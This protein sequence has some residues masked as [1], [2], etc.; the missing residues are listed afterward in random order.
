MLVKNYIDFT[1]S[2]IIKEQEDIIAK[3]A[4][5]LLKLEK[6]DNRDRIFQILTEILKQ[7]P[8]F[9]KF[10]LEAIENKDLLS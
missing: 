6:N 7:S 10:F 2:F 9:A 8:K 4:I 3:F 1:D 5:E